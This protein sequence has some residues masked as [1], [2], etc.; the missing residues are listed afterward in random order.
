MRTLFEDEED[1]YQPKRVSN[2][3]NNYY[4]E[5]ES[6]GD[7]NKNLSLEEYLKNIKPYWRDVIVVIQESDTWK[8]QLAIS[9]H[10]IYSK[11]TEEE[12]VMHSKSNNIT[13]YN[14]A[15]EIVDELFESPRS[16]YQGNLEKSM[17][18]SKFIFDLV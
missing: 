12:C 10:F 1:Y 14:D 9:I 5:C 2:F 7:T 8:I 18:G 3:W 17:R 13:S 6:N 11:D 15:N 16:R 4:I